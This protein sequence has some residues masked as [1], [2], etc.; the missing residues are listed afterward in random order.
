MGSWQ[1]PEE[2]KGCD[3]QDLLQDRAIHIKRSGSVMT[4]FFAWRFLPIDCSFEK[5]NK[6][7]NENSLGVMTSKDFDAFY[8]YAGFNEKA[9][10]GLS[11]QK[12]E[13]I[14]RTNRSHY[15]AGRPKVTGEWEGLIESISNN[16]GWM[17]ER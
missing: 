8:F 15:N 11:L 13:E 10:A 17:I 6:F 3:R 1:L 7:E 2:E 12:V 4:N 16:L 5:L 14:L 9:G